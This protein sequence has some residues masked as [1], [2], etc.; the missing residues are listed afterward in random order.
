M[1]AMILPDG[2]VIV[3]NHAPPRFAHQPRSGKEIGCEAPSGAGM[4]SACYEWST[5]QCY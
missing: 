1:T 2:M 4:L 5:Q 3:G